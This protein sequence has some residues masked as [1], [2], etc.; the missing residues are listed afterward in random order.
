[1]PTQVEVAQDRVVEV[2]NRMLVPERLHPGAQLAVYRHGECVVDLASGYSDAQACSLVLPNTPFPLISAGK[3]FGAVAVLQQVEA[4]RLGFDE[5][6][7]TYWPAFGANGK[8]RVLV[9]HLLSHR[10][11]FPQ[12]PEGVDWL[13]MR[14][15]G[16]MIPAIEQMPALYPP[17]LA[18]AYHHLTQQ[19]ACLE[20]VRRVDGRPFAEYMSDMVTAP[21]G[22]ANTYFGVSESLES[23]VARLHAMEPIDPFLSDIV[24]RFNA[25]ESHA[26]QAPLFAVST[27]RDMARF[28]A[29]I[30]AGGSLD[31]Q[32]VLTA[33]VVEEALRVEVEPEVDR[34]T[35]TRASW[36]LG[37]QLS[38]AVA[39]EERPFGSTSTARTFGHSGG[40]T[41]VSWADRDLDL[42]MC[43]VSN[44]QN[45]LEA[46]L[47]R[48]HV[49]SNAVRS[50]VGA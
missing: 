11:G 5:P 22:M 33:E 19:W 15:S 1:M 38:G 49:I 17:G 9:R 13:G 43:F 34:V 45:S 6:V 23:R 8:E 20:L 28:Y 44:G 3:P 12:F 2:F 50:L 10:G 47:Q 41:V 31:G 30:L 16:T 37:F 27:A 40:G 36:S 24:L 29:A 32:R 14:D 21:L 7:A 48:R 46:N 18:L 25:R 4:G 42:A 35:D 39:P 26:S